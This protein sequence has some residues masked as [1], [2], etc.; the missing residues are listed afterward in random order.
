M[1]I[2]KHNGKKVGSKVFTSYEEA[3]SYARKIVRRYLRMLNLVAHMYDKGG[4]TQRNPS[5][6]MYGY[7]VVAR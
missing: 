6:N 7:S 2:I 4:I 5:I 1:F 3:R